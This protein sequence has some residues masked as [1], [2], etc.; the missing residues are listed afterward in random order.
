[1]GLDKKCP[2]GWGQGDSIPLW[3]FE[4]NALKKRKK[5]QDA[6]LHLQ[7]GKPL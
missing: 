6:V 2:L 7:R 5:A 4:G 3:E 1:M